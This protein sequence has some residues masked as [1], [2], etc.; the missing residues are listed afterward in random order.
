MDLGWYREIVKT[1]N[2][3]QLT[4]NFDEIKSL[5]PSAWKNKVKRAVE[6]RNK[7][8]IKED[9]QTNSTEGKEVKTKTASVFETINLPDYNR[10]P[11]GEIMSLS[12]N[13]TKSLK[14]AK[15]GM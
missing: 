9:C 13:E 4:T 12:K 11:L 8:R 7:N 15:Y 5:R 2:E 14:M 6:E 3:Y 10:K 1:L